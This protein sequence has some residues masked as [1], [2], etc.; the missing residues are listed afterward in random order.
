M[1]VLYLDCAMGAAGDMLTAALLELLPNPDAFIEEMNALGLPGVHIER[2]PS[3]KCGIV[4]T[5]VSVTVDGVEEESL[6]YND[7]QGH[8][9]EHEHGH[10]HEHHDHHAQYEHAHSHHHDHSHTLSHEHSHAPDH[11]H[12]HTHSHEHA[13]RRLQDIE[14]IVRDHLPLSDKIKDDVMAVYNLIAEAESHVHG[15][16]V[17]DIHFHEVGTM[18][19][20]ADITAVC[21]LMDRL[22]G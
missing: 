6:D 20:V 9:H 18:D 4:G 13:H 17:A 10:D 22:A 19:A 16:P 21:L 15:V 5:Y 8:D 2:I 7:Q 14:H 1:K 3:V 12:N 11:D